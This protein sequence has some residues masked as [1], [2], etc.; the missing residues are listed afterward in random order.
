[1]DGTEQSGGRC[2]MRA[3]T[4][5][6]DPSIEENCGAVAQNAE[7]LPQSGLSNSLVRYYPRVVDERKDVA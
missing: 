4:Q 1:M 6:L 7:M 2:R 5:D 3:D